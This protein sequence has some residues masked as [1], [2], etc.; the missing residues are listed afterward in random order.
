[1]KAKFLKLAGVK[2]EK[3]F[4]KKF[5]T[6]ESFMAK[7]GKQLEKADDGF[8]GKIQVP[9]MPKIDMYKLPTTK[10]ENVEL[11]K[12]FGND[13]NPAITAGINAIP[14]IIG[15]IQSMNQ[16]KKQL[17]E[18]Q[19]YGKV[20]DV[21]AQAAS[22]RPQPA[23]KKYVR[24]EDQMINP[25][26][27]LGVGTNYLQA[28]DGAEIQNTYAPDVI[29]T[30]LGYEP[31]DDS[32]KVKQFAGGGT[33][34]G[35]NPLSA[36]SS[37]LGGLGSMAGSKLGGG[38]GEVGP[39]GQIA[40]S[41]GDVVSL[42]P[43][44]GT[45]AGAAI[46]LGGGLIGG[47][48]D[49]SGQKKRKEAQDKLQAN[50]D[51]A[52]LTSQATNFQN[53][54]SGFMEDGGWVSHD[55][56]PQVI[57]K[58]GE[59]DVDALLKPDP[60]MDTLRAGGHLKY[61]TPPS[62]RA[63]YTGKAEDGA[64]L[65]MGGDLE[66]YRGYAEPISTNPYLPNDGETVMFRGPSHD[67]GGMPISYGANGVEVEGGEPAMVMKDGGQKDNLVVFGNMHIPDYGANEIGDP[68]A[69]GMK[70]KKYIADLSKQEDKQNKIMT[71]A[72]DL[73]NSSNTDDPFDL[74]AFNSGKAMSLGANMKLK[75]LA[76]KKMNTA[77]VQ[78]AILETAEEHGLDSAKLAKQK[79]AAFGGKFT[80]SPIAEDGDK[81][82]VGG[83]SL[84][85]PLEMMYPLDLSPKVPA[86]LDLGENIIPMAPDPYSFN[87]LKGIP[88]MDQPEIVIPYKPGFVGKLG[89]EAIVKAKKTTSPASKPSFNDV[90]EENTKVN[91]PIDWA[92]YAQTAASLAAP[93][94][95]YRPSNTLDPNQIAP[96]ML[97]ASLN[98]VEPVQ[99]QTYQPM[100]APNAPTFSFQDQLNEITA[101]TRAA[102]RM[103]QGNP[104]VLSAIA[105]QAY[106]A[107]S[108][109][110]AD[111]FRMNQAEKQRVAE[112]N[113]AVLNDAQLKNLAMYDQQFVR[114][115][116]ARSKTK[117][118]SIEIAKSIA[119][120][121]AQNKLE[122]KQLRVMENMYPAFSFTPEGTA[123]K[124]PFQQ[125]VFNTAGA[126]NLKAKDVAPEGY[127][128]ETVLKK[129]KDT[130]KNGTIVKAFKNF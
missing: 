112:Q 118:Q 80:S 101:Q 127:E 17:K 92:P 84:N 14:S 69:K 26:N 33:L 59:Y 108:K 35:A 63:M 109:V 43:G 11:N 55:W 58:F 28:E 44:V 51:S 124:N 117:A 32:N 78:N 110:L 129:K 70:F 61:Y 15:S 34:A 88:T 62:E 9:K 37:A 111:Q 4:Y 48:I 77:A 85:K 87:P 13:Y 125:A 41:V 21:V 6:E 64:Q 67:D 36:I 75:N 89:K 12:S 81:I 128:F 39:A 29:Y 60:M 121:I 107:K 20:S 102:E 3:E 99:A 95:R 8:Y 105:A 42:I 94:L 22:T 50:L 90:E 83:I 38:T 106:Q 1:M 45:I 98:Q 122:N 119:D 25:E 16:E 86:S 46:K 73:I 65:A 7:Y 74:L 10:V 79:L 103:A 24:P 82:N 71:K 93:F 19:K 54:N 56:Q 47:L 49:A 104:E 97:A 72:T 100:L 68:K 113:R 31:L 114:Q 23:K 76:E 66:V 126:S 120:K 116:E 30:D 5:P 57:A 123:Y 18:L 91:K 2:N 27:P 53:A 52:M 130:A 96:E 115:S 40:N